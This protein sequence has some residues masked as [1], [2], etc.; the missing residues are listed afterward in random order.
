VE[1]HVGVKSYTTPIDEADKQNQEY[2]E[3]FDFL[4]EKMGDLEVT[5]EYKPPQGKTATE[6]RG[7]KVQIKSREEKKNSIT[8][9]PKPETDFREGA[10]QFGE[11]DW[12]GY[13]MRGDSCMAF[14]MNVY[15]VL[16]SLTD[17]EGQYAEDM[18]FQT[19]WYLDSLMD[20]AFYME[21]EVILTER[22]S[23]IS[24]LKRWQYLNDKKKNR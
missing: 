22:E 6:V 24:T 21:N 15:Y 2:K 20:L 12:P 17:S 8:I 14:V 4:V 18:S 23:L 1:C 10:I 7:G 19:K 13:F 16:C 5:P 11:D 3:V 9:L